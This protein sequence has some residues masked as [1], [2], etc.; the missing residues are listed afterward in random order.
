MS[1]LS[2]INLQNSL[3][4]SIISTSMIP[5]SMLEAKKANKV[6]VDAIEF[7]KLISERMLKALKLISPIVPVKP[8]WARHIYRVF[9]FHKTNNLSGC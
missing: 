3:I 9:I 8:P 2:E 4:S 7:T 1:N 5:T 6:G